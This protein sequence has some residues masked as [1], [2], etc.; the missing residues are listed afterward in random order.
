MVNKV[1]VKVLKS[2][3]TSVEN[4]EPDSI[5]ELDETTAMAWCRGGLVEIIT[6]I[7]VPN[8]EVPETK[9]KAVKAAPEK[10]PATKKVSKK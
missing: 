3:S 6:T 1:E 10:K 8:E 7:Q 9:E 5:M 4:H 2:F